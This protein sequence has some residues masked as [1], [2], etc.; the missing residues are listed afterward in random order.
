[1]TNRATAQTAYG[2]LGITDEEFA[3]AMAFAFPAIG[4]PRAE[5]AIALSALTCACG[6]TRIADIDPISLISDACPCGRR[7]QLWVGIAEYQE[8][9]E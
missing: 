5:A 9:A 2:T 3:A 4:H 8:G 7:W 6:I 1:M